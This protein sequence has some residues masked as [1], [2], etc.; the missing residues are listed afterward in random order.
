M[1]S[2]DLGVLAVAAA[3]VLHAFTAWSGYIKIG[4]HYGYFYIKMKK[5]ACH[6]I[7]GGPAH[8]DSWSYHSGHV[9][10]KKAIAFHFFDQA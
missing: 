8:C 6:D 10:H 2:P 5:R 9:Q 4:L 7:D 3:G 1:S